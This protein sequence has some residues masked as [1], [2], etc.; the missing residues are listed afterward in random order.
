MATP[1]AVTEL[2]TAEVEEAVASTAATATVKLFESAA[3][4]APSAKWS[5][6]EPALSMRRSVN[7]ATPATADLVVVP[8]SAPPPT[9][10]AV[11]EE[12]SP[13]TRLP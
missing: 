5:C 7:V 6:L 1:S 13:L 2:G 9:I 4:S 12:V 8:C 11:T 10:V 3:L